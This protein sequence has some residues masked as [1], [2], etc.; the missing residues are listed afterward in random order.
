MC[1]GRLYVCFCVAVCRLSVYLCRLFIDC[2]CLCVSI[3]VVVSECL[4]LCGGWQRYPRQVILMLGADV[5]TVEFGI[6]QPARKPW[7]LP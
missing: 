6:S 3:C 7:R 4:H 2:L 5:G 1:V